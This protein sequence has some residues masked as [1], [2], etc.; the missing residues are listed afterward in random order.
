MRAPGNGGR[1]AVH[2]TEPYDGATFQAPSACARR[3]EGASCVG[4][5]RGNLGRR[6][7]GSDVEVA[8]GARA[9]ALARWSADDV[10][11]GWNCF[12]LA[13]FER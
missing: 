11:S 3:G 4:K 1:T 6:A 12:G 2:A 9:G 8:Y 7:G 5:A 13:L 10:A